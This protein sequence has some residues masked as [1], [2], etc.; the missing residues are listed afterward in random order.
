MYRFYYLLSLLGVLPLS[1]M[2]QQPFFCGTL[3]PNQALWSFIEQTREYE[4]SETTYRLP[5]TLHIVR[6]SNGASNFDSQIALDALCAVNARFQPVGISF[7]L[8]SPIRFINRSDLTSP[9]S[10]AAASA[11]LD[12]FNVFRTIN[13]YY[14]NLANF[15]TCAFA[16]FPGIGPGTPQN[17]GG[18]VMGTNCAASDGA[19]LAHELGHFFNL[20]HTFNETS[21][22]PRDWLFAERVTRS[23]NEIAPRL[24]ANCSNAGDRF[25]DTPA[26]FLP[27]RWNCPLTITQTDT[28][29]DVFQP[30]PTLYMGYARDSCMQRFSMQQIAVMRATLANTSAPRGYLLLSPAP[31]GPVQLQTP[32]LLVPGLLDSQI[33]IGQPIFR[34]SQV[35]AAQWYHFR[36]FQ[37]TNQLLIDTVLADTSFRPVAGLLRLNRPY[38]WQV[39]AMGADALCTLPSPFF[40]FSAAASTAVGQHEILSTRVFPQPSNGELQITGEWLLGPVHLLL[41]NLQGKLLTSVWYPE[42]VTA[43]RLTWQLPPLASGMYMVEVRQLERRSRHKVLISRP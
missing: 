10:F 31:S 36:L 13:I 29:A 23:S 28:N 25:C 35:S 12:E 24:S 40:S 39:R 38:R 37:F 7:Y 21:D 33:S 8:A 14:T 15:G 43:S 17:Q 22:D 3:P 30:D 9:A 20:P 27:I 6:Q 41:Y 34:W 4:L 18:V 2:A 16:F 19:L 32:Q 26:D 5:V 1:V 42:P 11:I